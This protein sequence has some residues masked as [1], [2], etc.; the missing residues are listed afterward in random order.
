[1]DG[2]VLAFKKC[3]CH[4]GVDVWQGVNGLSAKLEEF[5]IGKE[6]DVVGCVDCLGDTVNLVCDFGRESLN[7]IV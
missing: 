5:F 6:V 3:T 1:M 7:R 2:F 4:D